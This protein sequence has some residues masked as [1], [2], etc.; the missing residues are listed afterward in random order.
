MSPEMV[1]RSD[2]YAEP[3]EP[4]LPPSTFKLDLTRAALVVGVSPA[5]VGV[6][7]ILAEPDAEQHVVRVVVLRLQEVRV[8]RRDHWKPELVA[9]REDALVELRLSFRLVRLHLEVVAVLE[10]VRV[11]RRRFAWLHRAGG[12]V[13]AGVCVPFCRQLP[14]K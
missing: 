12:V 7:P 8:V 10:G 5:A 1:T 13:C 14:A 2:L 11:P 4:A 6:A 3:K 9:E